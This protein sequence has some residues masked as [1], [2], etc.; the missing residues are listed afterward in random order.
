MALESLIKIVAKLRSKNGCP[1][2]KKQNFKSIK[3]PLIEESYEVVDAI[4]SKDFNKLKEELGDLLIQ[5]VFLSQ[6]SKEKKYFN[7]N[8]VIETAVEK[9]KR[10]HP[11][12][13][14]SVKVKGVKDVLKN[15]EKIKKSENN[16]KYILDGIPNIL[17]AL[18]K[19]KKVQNKVS[20]FGFDWKNVE[21]PMEKLNEELKEFKN[22]VKSNKKNKIEEELGDIIFTIVNI[23]RFY[24]INPEEAL[25]KTVKKFIK[26]F[27]YI[28]K[29]IKE[30]GKSIT[31]VSLEEMDSLWDEAKKE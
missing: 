18:L 5:I 29:K 2:D 25:N 1:W 11:H 23:G 16:N 4:N 30:S 19:A 24:H 26:R 3:E 10:R 21:G 9:L 20:R 8:D 6:L 12:I 22:A 28:E 13:F 17:P 27:N 15:W 31:D 14:G 7:I